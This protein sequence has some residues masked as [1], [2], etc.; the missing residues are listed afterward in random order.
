M[1]LYELSKL[2]GYNSFIEKT[3]NVGQGD[4]INIADLGMEKEVENIKWDDASHT[5]PPSTNYH[6]IFG[7]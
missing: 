6:S 5:P 4:E 1:S 3:E 7:E 2:E